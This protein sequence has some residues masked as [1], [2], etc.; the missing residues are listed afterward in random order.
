MAAD[1]LTKPL[2]DVA[3]NQ[4]FYQINLCKLLLLPE[5]Q[6]LPTEDK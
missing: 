3:H 1:G 5:P 4:F 6:E 2:D